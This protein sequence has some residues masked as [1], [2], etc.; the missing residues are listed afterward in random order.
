MAEFT[1][2]MHCMALKSTQPGPLKVNHAC[3]HLPCNY[4][5]KPLPQ[6]HHL[7]CEVAIAKMGLI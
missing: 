3:T 1:C 6:C 4:T 5:E 7:H 2:H